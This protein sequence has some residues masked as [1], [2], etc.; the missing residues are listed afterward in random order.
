MP[1]HCIQ[2]EINYKTGSWL[3]PFIFNCALSLFLCL[4]MPMICIWVMVSTSLFECSIQVSTTKKNES[5]S[6][7]TTTQKLDLSL[8]CHRKWCS[9]SFIYNNICVPK[10][11]KDILRPTESINGWIGS[12]I[13]IL[14]GHCLW[15]TCRCQQCKI[16]NTTKPTTSQP[17]VIWFQWVGQFL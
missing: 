16:E 11:K 17:N 9:V 4:C 1:I 12:W 15:Q 8:V 7:K 5:E 10:K 2:I 6:K 13:E 14:Y 3:S